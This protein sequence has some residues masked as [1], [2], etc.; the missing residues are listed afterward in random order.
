MFWQREKE[1]RADLRGGVSPNLAAVFS[2]DAFDNGKAN[3][4]A[5]KLGRPMEAVERFEQFAS[6]IHAETDPIISDIKSA[7]AAR[8][9]LTDFDF[10]DGARSSVFESIV[11]QIDQGLAQKAG[12]A[13][14]H[15]QT[16]DLPFNLTSLRLDL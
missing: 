12:V 6:V 16:A 10:R 2:D 3:A 5:F 7:L 15:R 11:D 14:D 9:G 1:S 8:R 13:L 4:A